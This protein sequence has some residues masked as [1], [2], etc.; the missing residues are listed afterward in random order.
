MI[1]LY[2]YVYIYM[3][4]IWIY[5][6]FECG[7]IDVF[8]FIYIFTIYKFFLAF[9]TFFKK[10]LLCLTPKVIRDP[11]ILVLPPA[12]TTLVYTALTLPVVLILIGFSTFMYLKVCRGIPWGYTWTMLVSSSRKWIPFPSKNVLRLFLS[13]SLKCGHQA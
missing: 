8:V 5:F 2:I 10:A 11:V 12:L 3:Y 4:F 9:V 7:F 6:S 1:I 13:L